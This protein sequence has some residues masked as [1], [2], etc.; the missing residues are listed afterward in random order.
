V[1]CGYSV[2]VPSGDGLVTL[3]SAR[4]RAARFGKVRGASHAGIFHDPRVV[5]RIVSQL[6]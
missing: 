3:E 2:D 6:R 4:S 1:L 5:E